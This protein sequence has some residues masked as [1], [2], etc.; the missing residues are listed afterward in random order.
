MF[1]VKATTVLSRAIGLALLPLMLVPAARAAEEEGHGT[2]SLEEI[3][4][5]VP[6]QSN[7]AET[8]L[9]VGVLSGE[10]LREK[11]T[12]TLGETLRNEIGVNNAS[13]GPSLGHPVIRGQSGSRVSVLTNGVGVTDASNQSPDHAEGVE[14]ALAERLEIVRGPATLLYGSGAVGGVVN[15]IDNRIPDRLAEDTRL[16]VEQSH[17]SVN[18][19]NKTVFRLDGSSGNFGFHTSGFRRESE[20]LNIPGFA[21]DEEALETLEEL[22]ADFLGEEHDHDE[23]HDEDHEGE[24]EDEFENSRGFISNSSAEAQGGSVG[25]SWVGERGF[26]GFSVNILENDY[27]LPG[28]T[29]SHGHEEEGHDE[30]EEDH[31]ED[32]E[33]EGHDHGDVEFVRIDLEKIRYDVKAGLDLE[34]G[35]FDR[36]EGILG[37]TDYEHAEVEYFEDGDR[38]TGTRY[39]NKGFEGRFTLSHAH[40]ADRSGVWGLQLSS[41]EFAAIGEEAFIPRSD[42]NN[43][44]VF[45]VERLVRG[46]FTG[47]LGLRIDRGAVDAGSGCDNTDN[48]VSLSGSVLYDVTDTSNVLVGLSRSQRTPTVEELFSNVDRGTCDVYADPEQFTLHAAT[49]LLEIGN[50]DLDEETSNNL[51]LGFRRFAGPVTGQ[52]SVYRN[53]IDDF[54]FLDFTGE[55]F[56]GQTIARYVAQDATFTGIEGEVSVALLERGDNALELGLFGD[57]VR[58]E[59]DS[60]GNIPRIPAAKYGAELRYSGSDWSAHLHVTRVDE[61]DDAGRLELPTDG[62]TI[63]SLYADY[64]WRLRGGSELKVFLRGDNL[65]DEE[66]RNHASFLKNYAPEPGRS[67]RVGVRFDY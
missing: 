45:G 17:N 67:F 43:I 49:N 64:H 31:D 5:T 27:G 37:F 40:S 1:Q 18:D 4:V 15:V 57:M 7:V 28:G 24:H 53:E 3:L 47:E 54:V 35:L 23:G 60:G 12:S 22:V 26:I 8:A 50:P 25:L 19:E 55:E 39:T 51:E 6:F 30:G 41:T 10:E 42:I 9:P 65:L 33:E 52:V 13:F 59:L 63:V 36:F 46:R 32:H 16:F 56:E 44:G 2:E 34:N 48:A 11:V 20:D 58:A 61:Q 29:H 38:E 66:I 14:P 62:Y 21:V